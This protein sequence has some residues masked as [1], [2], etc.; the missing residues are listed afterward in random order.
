MAVA[1]PGHLLAAV[2]HA[3]L[4]SRFTAA[5]GVCLRVRRPA[6]PNP[7]RAGGGGGGRPPPPPP[8]RARAPPRAR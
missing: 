2:A 1:F 5:G 6:R 4:P 7:G 3:G 8:P